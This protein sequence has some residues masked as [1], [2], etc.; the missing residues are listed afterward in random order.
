MKNKN[1]KIW[2]TL[3]VLGL[4]LFTNQLMAQPGGEKMEP[5][6]LEQKLKNV[7][8]KISTPLKLDKAQKKVVNDAFTAFF[9]SADQLVDRNANPPVR[10]D[11]E[12]I[13]ALSKVRD[14]KIKQAIT[15][16]SFAKYLEL[17]KALRPNRD[18]Q[19]PPQGG[20]ENRLQRKN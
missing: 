10:P 17:E 15:A 2:S 7:E 16:D 5:P 13:D 1:L 9:N 14:E 19:G 3:V 6:T 4:M 12:K 11:K 8:E 20:G 18:R